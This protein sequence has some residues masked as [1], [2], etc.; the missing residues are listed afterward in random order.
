M[1]TIVSATTD[2]LTAPASA[3]TLTLS[4][5]GTTVSLSWTSVTK[6]TKY[7]IYWNN[8]SSAVSAQTVYDFTT[9]GT[10]YSHTGR[11]SGYTYYYQVAA[12]NDAGIGP[13]STVQYVTVPA[14]GSL[15][16]VPSG[17]VAVTV[18]TSSNFTAQVQY[19]SSSTDIDY[20]YAYLSSSSTYKIRTY[21]TYK[22][23]SS[24]TSANY[25]PTTDAKYWLYIAGGSD[26]SYV[27]YYDDSSFSPTTSGYYVFKVM[28]YYSST[29]AGYH[30]LGIYK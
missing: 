12:V 7:Y 27:D 19:L 6:A 23:A 26:T 13:R 10:T 4:A 25:T 28:T 15:S 20:F 21:D 9:T 16:L 29:S 17:A 24:L 3:P 30:G 1:S 18:G 5:S 22:Y 11:T 14:L 8:S 2:D